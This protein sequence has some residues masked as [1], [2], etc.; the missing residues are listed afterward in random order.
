MDFSFLEP[1][2]EE[3]GR[4]YAQLAESG[5][6]TPAAVIFLA[7][8]VLGIVKTGIKFLLLAAVVLFVLTTLGIVVL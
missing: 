6:L 5:V 7:S 3:A 4:L 1:F 8:T 2:F